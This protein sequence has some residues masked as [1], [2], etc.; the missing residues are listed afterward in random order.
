MCVCVYVIS[1]RKVLR[2]SCAHQRSPPC[3][4]G[5]MAFSRRMCA[6]TICSFSAR[7][8]IDARVYFRAS[9]R[10]ACTEMAAWMRERERV[11]K[12]ERTRGSRRESY[13]H[14]KRG[15]EL[16]HVHSAQSNSRGGKKSREVNARA[17]GYNI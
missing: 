4:R 11:G 2:A 5:K 3:M 16:H 14:C 8:T 7:E 9:P 12:R 15:Y 6:A 13:C 1:A 10:G 17:S